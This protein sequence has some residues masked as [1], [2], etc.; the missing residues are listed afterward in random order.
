MSK[1]EACL[2]HCRDCCWICRHLDKCI[3]G[4]PNSRYCKKAHSEAWCAY[5]LEK[6]R[7]IFLRHVDD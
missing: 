4:W 5:T 2:A 1:P 3:E 7:R 6:F